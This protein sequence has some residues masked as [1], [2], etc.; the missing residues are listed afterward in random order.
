MT[1][2][3]SSLRWTTLALALTLA[4][5]VPAW[6]QVAGGSTTVE[7]S[8]TESTRLA[9]GWSVKKTLLGKTIYND[10][11]QKVGQVQDLI[12]APDRNLSYVIIGAGGFIGIGRHDVA[13]PVSQIQDKGGRLVMPGATKD[14]I[15]AMPTFTYAENTARREQFIAAADQDIAKGRA[16]LVE[17]EKKGGVAAADAKAKIDLQITALQ[18]DLKSTEGKLAEMKQA[19]AARWRDF[20]AAV[21][22]ATARLR[23]SIDTAAG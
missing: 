1:K 14:S 6:A 17:L 20:E 9:M 3:A 18:M 15:K 13:I 12:I 21:S 2:N 23:K 4:A 10:A 7:T 22:A 19:T 16:K 11:G 5:P 8:T